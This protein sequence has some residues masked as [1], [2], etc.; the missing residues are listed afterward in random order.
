MP[1]KTTTQK[2]DI[3]WQDRSWQPRI[4]R[5]AAQSV[6]SL[7]RSRL[8]PMQPAVNECPCRRGMTASLVR[9]VILALR[10]P[11]RQQS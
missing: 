9:H 10:P 1:A 7:V 11:R 6:E 3:R 8:N 4:R 5:T 2:L